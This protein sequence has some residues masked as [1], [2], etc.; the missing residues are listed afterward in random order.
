MASTCV[1]PLSALQ[2]RILLIVGRNR[3]ISSKR[4]ASLITSSK[5]NEFSDIA[6]AVEMQCKL[7]ALQ[8][9]II[10][11]PFTASKSLYTASPRLL[12]WMPR[13]K[14]PYSSSFNSLMKSFIPRRIPALL[15]ASS[16][17]LS[18]CASMS[19]PR[20]TPDQTNA[21]NQPLPPVPRYNPEGWLPPERMEQFKSPGKGAVYRFCTNDCPEATPKYL[22]TLALAPTGSSKP[23]P[24]RVG[25][26]VDYVAEPVPMMAQTRD[27]QATIET[28]AAMERVVAEAE[29]YLRDHPLPSAGAN[30]VAL[31]RLD[32]TSSDVSVSGAP[33]PKPSGSIKPTKLSGQAS[34]KSHTD[35]PLE[36]PTAKATAAT[37]TRRIAANNVVFLGDKD[38]LS[39]AG[40]KAINA[41]IESAKGAESIML[42][43]YAGTVDTEDQFKRLSI[44]R[45]LAVRVELVS[46][47]VD[48][49][50]IRILNPKF[51]LS[52]PEN[53][54]SAANRSVS[55]T[56]RMPSDKSGES[57]IAKASVDKATQTMIVKTAS[58]GNAA[59]ET[60]S[61]TEAADQPEGISAEKT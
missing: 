49:E 55:I 29:A 54:L 40:R 51:K 32:N 35:S 22:R 9:I 39:D 44:A 46:A 10:I 18:G 2:K 6:S 16:L 23:S 19:W 4:L 52:D 20:P 25:A 17:A 12:S 38:V 48:R 24:S 57:S 53:P 50:K 27:E 33:F 13:S 47:G 8:G 11:E 21:S 5:S 28:D 1:Q 60:S 31:G 37:K 42:R 36:A 41:L 58:P 61:H 26:N 56:L 34:S 14:P 30:K 45:A 59:S 3:S 7:F 15:F 43:G